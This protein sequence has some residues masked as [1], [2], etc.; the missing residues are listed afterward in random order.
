VSRLARERLGADNRVLLV[1]VP[2]EE[3]PAET[4]AELAEA[5]A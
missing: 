5:T 4:S 1:F 3:P 2:A